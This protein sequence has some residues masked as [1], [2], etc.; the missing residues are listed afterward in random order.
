M[1]LVLGDISCLKSL[2]ECIQIRLPKKGSLSDIMLLTTD[3]VSAI[4]FHTRKM[5]FG[6][7]DEIK[8]PIHINPGLVLLPWDTSC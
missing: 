8:N 3:K 7:S 1:D 6:F 2:P 5:L 4:C